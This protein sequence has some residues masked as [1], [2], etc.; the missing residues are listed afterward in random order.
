[1]QSVMESVTVWMAL[2][3]KTAVRILADL[4]YLHDYIT[5]NFLVCIHM[6]M[7][8]YVGTRLC[9]F[10]GDKRCSSSHACIRSFQWCNNQLDCDD[11]SDENDCSKYFHICNYAPTYVTNII[12][13]HMRYICT[14]MCSYVWYCYTC[15]K[16]NHQ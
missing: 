1:M 13:V 5:R 3:K 7:Y 12:S 8:V 10:P 16:F 14:Y 6:Y 2:M 9:P 11:G 15:S 4:L